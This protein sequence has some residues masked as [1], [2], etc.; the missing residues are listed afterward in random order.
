MSS[1][2]KGLSLTNLKKDDENKFLKEF[3]SNVMKNKNS[4]PENPSYWCVLTHPASMG[5]TWMA[6]FLGFSNQM[7]GVNVLNVFTVVLLKGLKN[8]GAELFLTPSKAAAT[9]GVVGFI[10][11][12]IAPPF[13]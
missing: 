9:V 4:L 10:G 8:S 7:T 11:N 1:L 6:M 13:I 5:S 3:K 12:I 2:S